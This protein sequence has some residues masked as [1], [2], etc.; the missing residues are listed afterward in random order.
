NVYI[1]DEESY[2][3]AGS[4]LVSDRSESWHGPKLD[5]DELFEEG[6]TY[7]VTG[8]VKLIAGTAGSQ[9]LKITAITND[10][11]DNYHTVATAAGVTD[12]EWVELTGSITLSAPPVS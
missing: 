1:T 11:S 10:G 4:M 9:D 2:A 6:S 5:V 3:G 8:W 12:G 7:T